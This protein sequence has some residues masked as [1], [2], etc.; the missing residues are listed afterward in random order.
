MPKMTIITLLTAA[1]AAFAPLAAQAET[2]SENPL[3]GE[4]GK[5]DKAGHL[6]VNGI[7]YY[8][9]IRGE[10]EPLLLLHGG[11]GQ[12]EMFGA[13]LKTLQEKRQV[14][15]VDLQGHGRTPL[16]TR[17]I[18]LPAIGADMAELVE[19]L[20]YD[21][22]DVLGYSFGGGVALHMAAVAPDRV[23]RL[24][25]ASAPFARNGFFPE[26][27]PQQAAVSGVMAEMMKET[28]MYK[29][30][31][32]VAPDVSA[33]P[34]L[35]DAMGAAMRVDYDASDAVAKLAVPV[36]LVF[37]DSDMIRPEH[38]VEFYQKLGGGLKDA[39]WMREHMSK[40]RLAILPGLT[41]YEI[42][43]APALVS[44]ALPFLDGQSNTQSWAGQVN[45]E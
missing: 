36:M 20:G 1:L 19:K 18:D 23:R 2:L 6:T 17:P 8:Y 31:A 41:H 22:V 13:N 5:P 34:K 26:M 44:T 33:F 32:A 30:Y 3:Q 38:I 39:G 15:G 28:P 40:N 29:S 35:L 45:G 24:V 43:A 10:G 37:G 42:F 9:E 16:G 25:I 21:K 12:I 14:I 4:A 27:L 7:D 11:L